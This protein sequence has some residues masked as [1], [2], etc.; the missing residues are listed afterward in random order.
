MVVVS[1]LPEW[2]KKRRGSSWLCDLNGVL[3]PPSQTEWAGG[4]NCSRLCGLI[5]CGG[6]AGT[7]PL[8]VTLSQDLLGRGLPGEQSVAVLLP[9]LLMLLEARS[10]RARWLEWDGDSPLLARLAWVCSVTCPVCVGIAPEQDV[11]PGEG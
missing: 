5:H 4:G 2:Q 3:P 9:P 6:L 7:G 8:L 10:Q 1:A 11:T